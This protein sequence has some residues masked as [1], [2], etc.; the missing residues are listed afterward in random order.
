MIDWDKPVRYIETGEIVRVLCTDLEGYY[1]VVVAFIDRNSNHNSVY[2]IAPDGRFYKG[3]EVVFEN[4]PPAPIKHTMT[5]AFH[6]F[7]GIISAHNN[8][9]CQWPDQIIA[10]KTI[11]FE[12]GEGL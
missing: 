9:E 10:K 12:E 4:V 11:T 3:S 2:S 8:V 6:K 7:S 1:S 5:L